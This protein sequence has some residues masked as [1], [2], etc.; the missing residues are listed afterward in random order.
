MK[1][2]GAI[3]LDKIFYII[4][5]LIVMAVGFIGTVSNRISALETANNINTIE[6]KVVI[7]KL[8]KLDDKTSRILCYLGDKV[9][10]CT[11]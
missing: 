11:K 8:N 4:A 3:I 10:N 2:L 9:G 5:S 7:E 6:H 1:K